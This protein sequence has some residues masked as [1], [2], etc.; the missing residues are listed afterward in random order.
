MR[1]P[2]CGSFERHRTLWLYLDREGVLDGAA[3]LLHLAPEPGLASRLRSAGLRYVSADLD[4]GRAMV[5]TD[6]SDMDFPEAQFDLVIC[7]HVL[8]HVPDDRA[9]MR[10]MFRVLRPG[11]RAVMMHPVDPTREDTY[12]DPAIISREEREAAFGQWDHVRIYGRDLR[13]R[14]EE[15]CFEV[16]VDRYVDCLDERLVHRHRLREP[17]RRPRGDD[18]YVCTRPAA[19]R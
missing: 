4:P 9:A 19:S 3:D 16:A 10:E 8:E 2:R 14:L 7:C 6:V 12:E 13:R 5:A 15:A 17:P 11:G 18:I 1:C